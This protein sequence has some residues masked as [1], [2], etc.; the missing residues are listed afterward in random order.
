MHHGT[1]G[2]RLFFRQ[3][4]V[5]TPASKSDLRRRLRERRKALSPEE[6]LR[7]T[8]RVAIHVT[9]TRLFLVSRR[10]ACYFPHD[11][12]IDPSPILERIWSMQKTGYLPVLSPLS[13]DRLWFA[14]VRPG[15][16]LKSNRFG[17]AEPVVSANALVR[18]RDLDLVLL[19]LVAFDTHGNRL[20]M[21]GGFYD[22]SLEF[23]R[24]RRHLHKP[25]LLGLAH[26][27]QRVDRLKPD[28]WDIPLAGIVTDQAIY[29]TPNR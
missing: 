13:R 28:P 17:I 20:G 1:G 22:R 12:E 15:I 18:A 26:E 16:K 8:R 29:D 6:R 4:F 9:A 3:R 23:L 5:S 14:P 24:H 27:C 7:A 25:R 19:P 2:G 10:V 11:G 21:G